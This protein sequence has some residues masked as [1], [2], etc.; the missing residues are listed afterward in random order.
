MQAALEDSIA[1]KEAAYLESA[2]TG[3][4]IMG[5]DNYIKGTTGAA[6][7]RRKMGATEQNRV[8]SRSSVSYRPNQ[9]VWASKSEASKR[10]NQRLTCGFDY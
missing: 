10:R 5:Y 3:N 9:G 4:I 1:Q 6:A 7:Q 8:F 2:P